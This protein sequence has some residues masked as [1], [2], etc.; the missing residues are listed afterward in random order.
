[1]SSPLESTIYLL[2]GQAGPYSISSY[3][4]PDTM[5]IHTQGFRFGFKNSGL[6]LHPFALSLSKGIHRQK[7]GSTSSPRTVYE[8]EAKVLTPYVPHVRPTCLIDKL[9]IRA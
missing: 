6:S 7:R 2:T 4:Q 3:P 8:P 1:M 9:S 5:P